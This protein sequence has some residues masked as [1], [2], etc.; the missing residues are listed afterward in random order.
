MLEKKSTFFPG[1]SSPAFLLLNKMSPRPATAGEGWGEGR[2]VT[3]TG[4]NC[5]KEKTKPGQNPAPT[6][7]FAVPLKR[8]SPNTT[9]PGPRAPGSS[10]NDTPNPWNFFLPIQMKG[11]ALG[12]L[13][14]TVFGS[15]SIIRQYETNRNPALEP[16]ELVLIRKQPGATAVG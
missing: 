5:V 4:A 10:T 2:Q 9:P 3:A 1:G 6:T 8:P 12:R 15:G 7:S 16:A 14:V 13:R 11:P